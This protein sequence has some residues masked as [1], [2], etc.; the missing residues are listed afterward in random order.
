MAGGTKETDPEKLA[1]Y[2]ESFMRGTK[3]KYDKGPDAGDMWFFE[4]YHHLQ[5]CAN[6]LRKSAAPARRIP[7]LN[8]TAEVQS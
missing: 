7:V 6:A 4:L 1:K 8:A 5:D 3:K 2:C